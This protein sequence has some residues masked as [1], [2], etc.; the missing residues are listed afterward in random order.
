MHSPTLPNMRTVLLPTVHA[1]LH[2]PDYIQRCGLAWTSWVFPMEHFCGKLA[3]RITS[4]LHPYATLV[5]YL[6]RSAQLS[7]LKVCYQQ[8]WDLLAPDVMEVELM[9]SERL[10]PECEPFLIH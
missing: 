10:Y 8:V 6:R 9:A 2:V 4:H 1:L 5:L 7:Q 3:S